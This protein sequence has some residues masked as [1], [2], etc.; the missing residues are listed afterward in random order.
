MPTID[1]ET[2]DFVSAILKKERVFTLQRLLSLLDC[3]R[4]TAQTK[5]S[6]WKTL[7]SYNHNSKYYTFPEIPKFNING[8]WCYKNI[9]FSKHGNLKKTIIHLVNSSEAGLTGKELSALLGIPPQNFVHHFKN[10]PGICREKHGGLYIHFSDQAG[11][12]QQQMKN[13]LVACRPA[14]KD[15]IAEGDAIMILVA[16]LNHHMISLKDRSVRYTALRFMFRKHGRRLLSPWI[17]VPL[18]PRKQYCSALKTKQFSTQRS[19]AG[20]YLKGAPLVLT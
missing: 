18:K 20:S 14:A 2:I 1:S 5:L 15:T 12:Y 13:Q 6:Q 7:T 4:R 3:S 8:L 10:C 17:S 16:I 9:A 19:Y 11:R